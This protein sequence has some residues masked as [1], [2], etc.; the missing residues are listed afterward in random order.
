MDNDA[1][2]SLA[3]AEEAGFAEGL[4]AELHGPGAYFIL[5]DSFVLDQITNLNVSQDFDLQLYVMP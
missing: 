5:A 3:E 4:V 2:E 1:L